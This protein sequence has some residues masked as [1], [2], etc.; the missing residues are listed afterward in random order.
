MWGESCGEGAEVIDRRLMTADRPTSQLVL[1]PLYLKENPILQNTKTLHII[2]HAG[3][4]QSP[5]LT[6]TNVPFL[7]TGSSQF[8]LAF[9]IYTYTPPGCFAPL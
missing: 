3:D 1:T 9:T 7:N 5:Y 2:V 8:V 6:S 4:L